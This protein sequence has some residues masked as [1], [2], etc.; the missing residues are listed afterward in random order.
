MAIRSEKNL[1]KNVVYFICEI[2][3]IVIGIFIAVQINNWN[4]S[5]KNRL[6]EKK[7]LSLLKNDLVTEKKILSYYI[8]DL[9]QGE[10]FLEKILINKE[11]SA[12]LD[13]IGY[14]LE[15]G[16]IQQKSNASYV[17]LKHS[18]KLSLITNQKIKTN[19]TLFYET[20]YDGNEFLS[21][22]SQDF[23][24]NN[25]RPYLL[26]NFTINANELLDIKDV[27]QAFND[28]LFMNLVNHQNLMYK[29]I[30]GRLESNVLVVENLLK[31]I[32]D[33]L[34]ISSKLEN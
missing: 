26:T 2:F 24:S 10:S 20:F 18:G 11:L 28:R 23:N 5:K 14:Y 1:A 34:E 27:K 15:R 17:N 6:E 21:S 19:I 9:A 3:I 30:R 12:N 33:E 29:Q 8:K 25:I 16:Y 32:I 13:S 31:E 4:D 22:W 7:A